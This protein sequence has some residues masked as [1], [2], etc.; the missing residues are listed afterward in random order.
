M[1]YLEAV[2]GAE[3]RKFK[4]GAADRGRGRGRGDPET[5]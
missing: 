4:G 1:G 2:E 3:R 5:T